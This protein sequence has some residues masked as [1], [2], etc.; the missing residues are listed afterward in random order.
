MAGA[1][2]DAPCTDLWFVS[3]Q[4]GP[5]RLYTGVRE[6]QEGDKLASSSSGGLIVCALPSSTSRTS[7]CTC[8]EIQRSTKKKFGIDIPRNPAF[9]IQN[10]PKSES[11]V[12]ISLRT[13]VHFGCKAATQ[14]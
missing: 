3:V 8:E 1:E 11:S 5:I 4:S 2:C 6:D 13:S 7:S 10:N 9:Q 14:L 12:W